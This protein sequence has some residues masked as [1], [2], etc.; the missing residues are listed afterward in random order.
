MTCIFGQGGGGYDYFNQWYRSNQSYIKFLIDKDGFYRVSE[1]DLTAAGVDVSGLDPTAI[2]VIYRGREIPIRT[3]TDNGQ[4]S[5]IEFFGKRN[6]G[7]LDSL[8]YRSVIPPF[9]YD[10]EQQP[11]RFSSFFSDTSA[12]FITWD[13]VG[14]RRYDVVNSTDNYDSFNPEPWYRYRALREHTEKYFRGGGSSDNPYHVLNPDYVTG[15]GFVGMRFEFGGPPNSGISLVSTPGFANSGRPTKIKC[16]AVHVTSSS[17]HILAIQ[18]DGNEH[19]RDTTSNIN[20]RTREFSTNQVLGNTTTIRYGALG[21]GVI[22]DAGAPCWT[23]IEYDRTF[24]MDDSS[25]TIVREWTKTDTT[26]LR[27]F[28]A[29]VS[30]EAW[31]YD[32]ILKQ[33]VAATVVGDTLKFLVPGFPDPRD[34]YIYTDKSLLSPV[35]QNQTSLTNLS[36]PGNEAEFVIIT[37][38]KF[39]N[40]ANLYA[41]YRDT[42]RVNQLS[43]KVV[44]VDE[45][46]DE[47]GY[48]SLNPLAI[49]NFCKYTMDNWSTPPK[50]FMLWGKGRPAPKLDNLYNYIPTFGEPANDY[51][52][53]SNFDRNSTSV[54]PEAAI[55]RVSL[56][57]DSE[58]LNYL[59]K[60]NK[61]E[62]MDYAYWMK[63]A[64]FLGGGKTQAE[65]NTISSVM[66]NAFRPHL[67]N[68]PM[69]G[70]VFTFQTSNSGN[71][72]NTNKTSKEF[73]DRGVGLIHF[74]GHSGTN[75]F[76]VDILEARLYQNFDRYPFMIAFGCYGGDFNNST[77]S[78]G[79]RFILEPNRGSIGYLANTSAGFL[80]QLHLFGEDLYQVMFGDSTY[81][82]PIGV[83]LQKVI[84]KYATSG[85]FASNILTINHSKQM[86]LQGDPSV[87]LRFPQKPDLQ[88]SDPDLY[89]EPETISALDNE[90]TLNLI[91]HNNGRTFT[92]S[93]QIQITHRIPNGSITTYPE[94]KIGP[95]DYIDSIS[96]PIFNTLGPDLAGL[97]D[98]QV[99]VD[100]L[101]TLDE[102]LE[103]NNRLNNEVIIQG[104]IPAIV[105]PY[106]YAIVDSSRVSLVAS[107]FIITREDNMAYEF[108]LD[109]SHTFTS[110]FRIGSGRIMGSSSIVRWN[111]SLDL[112][113][114][115]VYYWRVRLADTYPVQ[116]NESSFK[117]IPGKTGWSQSDEPQFFRNPTSRITMDQTNHIWIFDNFVVN[118]H[119][120]IRSFGDFSQNPEFFLGPFRSDNF[121]GDGVC[122]TAISQKTLEPSFLNTFY[123]DWTF[124]SAPNTSGLIDDPLQPLFDHII[125][126]P[127][128][129]Y[130]LM[131]SSRNPKFGEWEPAWFQTLEMIGVSG[132]QVDGLKN[133]DRIIILGRKGGAPGTAIVIRKPNLPIGNNPPRYDLLID[134]SASYDSASVSSINIGPSNDWAEFNM[135]WSTVDPF[136]QEKT[137]SNIYGVRRDNTEVLL[138][139][140]LEIGPEVISSINSDEFPFLRLEG[141]VED[142]SFRTAPQ[143]EFWEVYFEPAPDVSVDPSYAFDIPDT[144]DE[145]QVIN[146]KMGARNLTEFGTDSLLVRYSL[147]RGDR[148]NQVIG[149]Q[150]YAPL[151][152]NEVMV[153]DYRFHTDGRELEGQVT[154]IIELNPDLDQVEHN[155]FNNFYF[156][157]MHVRT[158]K[159]GPILDVTV[160]GKRLMDGD[161]VAPEPE[162]VIELNDENQYFPVAISDST[163]NIW[164]GSDRTF[165]LNEQIFIE[166]N[167]KI[168]SQVG[169]LPQNKARLVFH[170]GLLD[171]GEYTLAVQGYDFKGNASATDEYVIHF[172]V[173]N[174]KAISKVLPYPNPFSTSTRFAYTLTGGEL[175]YIF[176]IRI[177]TISGRLVK[178]LDLLEREDVYMGRNLTET[179]WNGTDEFGDPLANGVYIYK[180]HIQFRD[181]DSVKEKDEGIDQYF[182]KAG[183]GK[184]YLMK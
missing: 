156:H 73:I 96:Y 66:R 135:D 117:Y 12:Y 132:E 55:G 112:Q 90:Y 72:S 176:E 64:V 175:P 126:T 133:G 76:D 146:L 95:V 165:R 33:S 124:A 121:P 173:V 77:L 48:G 23:Y 31:L 49:K 30:S 85:N 184:V 44:F 27:F 152:A 19:F 166:G 62:H 47:F 25:T 35:I 119:A 54:T 45:I 79:E 167:P 14:T 26:Y 102:Y 129:D 134:L 92:D 164:F 7:H 57:E 123:G 13:S 16:R 155:E 182:N 56:I 143:L 82:A 105:S 20:I 6:D 122:Y 53:V 8:I 150:R 106:E 97:N 168:E 51:E 177:Y 93:F 128:G 144:V 89:F 42:C 2:Q 183:F 131:V 139:G 130:F 87:V 108:E 32:P 9:G 11:T 63:E 67:E 68:T 103:T 115:Q 157:R 43:S 60:V 145:G 125:N 80:Q 39:S 50:F 5:F 86:N 180:A 36:D 40:S 120:Y 111:P 137:I 107:T 110:E 118:L 138:I 172:N 52:Y 163:Y 181:R 101:D 83:I 24:D 178:T 100:A 169:Q 58:G 65:Q 3:A 94:K 61:Y 91:V 160:D 170:P 127:D 147:L 161:I 1:S 69:G 148:S 59:D 114:G 88:I 159:I 78:F 109:T 141:R 116:W 21:N 153:L 15:E 17:N 140:N 84:D 38:R 70:K 142:R 22:P 71:I 18:V 136:N 174:E 75:I 4:L 154:L 104:D 46:Y 34:L 162:I 74:F 41:Q 151:A 158:D 81:G 99:F 10:P 113:P 149:Y 179:F 98:F 37:H 171:D 28:N 29:D